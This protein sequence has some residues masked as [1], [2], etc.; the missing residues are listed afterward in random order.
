MAGRPARALCLHVSRPLHSL[1]RLCSLRVVGGPD[2][3]LARCGCG[4]GWWCVA[5]HFVN[6]C[7]HAGWCRRS[8]QLP[9]LEAVARCRQSD[10]LCSRTAF[11]PAETTEI[12]GCVL[13]ALGLRGGVCQPA[14]HCLPPTLCLFAL[15]SPPPSP[16]TH[17]RTHTQRQRVRY[18][19]CKKNQLFD[20]RK[21]VVPAF[22]SRGQPVG[23]GSWDVAGHTGGIKALFGGAS[24][25]A[26][27]VVTAR[28]D[29]LRLSES[30]L[31]GARAG[32]GSSGA[33]ACRRA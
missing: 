23:L 14:K 18:T 29:C 25:E 30:R 10:L 24:P 9:G 17:T 12:F 11:S 28:G 21:L 32:G 20:E 22:G 15:P 27:S 31:T 13:C 6:S 26:M 1:L 5:R 8:R 16:A 7:F 4:C 3:W 19:P 2:G 33:H